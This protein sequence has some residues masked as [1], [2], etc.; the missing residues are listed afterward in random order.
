LTN[1]LCR[2]STRPSC[3]AWAPTA[4]RTTTTTLSSRFVA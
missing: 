2:T 3:P 4:T 1:F